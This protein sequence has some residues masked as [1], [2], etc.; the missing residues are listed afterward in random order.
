MHISVVSPVY[1]AEGIVD[2]LA[3]K[4]TE[5]VSSITGSFEIILIEDGSKDKSW[6]KIASICRKHPHVKG[7]KLSR[8]FGQHYAITAGTDHAKGEWVVVMDCDLQDKPSEIIKLYNKAQEGYDIVLARRAER[9][10]TFFK[11]FFSKIFYS[12]LSYLT[13]NRQDPAVANFGIYNC[14]VITAIASMREPIRYF[15]TMVRWV[16]FTKTSID[17]D[18]AARETG[19]SNYNFRRL[20]KLAMDIILAHSIKPVV[21]TIKFGFLV[22]LISFLIGIGTLY[23]YLTGKITVLGYT[24]LLIS[25]WFLAG[26]MF[27][28]L[29]VI[30]L[31][32]GKTFEGVKNRP[33][34]ITEQLL[35]CKD[36]Q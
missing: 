7:I 29:G 17:V 4:I 15:P 34:Y 18:H 28:V 32:L 2:E 5:T 14:K 25:I 22:A 12:L 19:R 26:L 11:K 23:Q 21:L 16:G 30:G 33:I 9:N 13:G 36:E 1:Q 10:D 8:N 6:E 35:N 20:L 3:E 24:S 31:Y 27:V